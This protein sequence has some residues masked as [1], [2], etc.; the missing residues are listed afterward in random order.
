MVYPA[1]PLFRQHQQQ[2]GIRKQALNLI[3]E[4][5]VKEMLLRRR[6]KM[7]NHFLSARPGNPCKHELPIYRCAQP[8]MYVHDVI[9]RQQA[10]ILNQSGKQIP[11]LAYGIA[12]TMG[13]NPA[14][15]KH[16]PLA[17]R[18]MRLDHRRYAAA[19]LARRSHNKNS[20]HNRE[21]CFDKYLVITDAVFI[22]FAKG[23]QRAYERPCFT[24]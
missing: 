9:K 21:I 3:L 18:L 1:H 12:V 4:M 10:D 19:R 20:R 15:M 22:R 14:A 11:Q 16:L 13:L 24:R 6:M 17:A 8:D 5:S 2:V 23:R 7:H